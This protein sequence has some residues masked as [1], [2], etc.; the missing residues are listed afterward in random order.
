MDISKWRIKK[1]FWGD[2]DI[3]SPSYVFPGQIEART[4]TFEEAIRLLPVLQWE[5]YRMSRRWRDG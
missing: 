3:Y 1:S 5:H 4:R 2:W